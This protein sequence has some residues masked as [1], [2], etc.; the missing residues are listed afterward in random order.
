MQFAEKKK[1]QDVLYHHDPGYPKSHTG[2]SKDSHWTFV[3]RKR[4][5]RDQEEGSAPREQA[6]KCQT[7]SSPYRGGLISQVSPAGRSKS[8]GAALVLI[9]WHNLEASKEKARDKS[10][11]HKSLGRGKAGGDDNNNKNAWG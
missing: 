4:K 1:K 7:I 5:D 8:V 10:L 2:Q 11:I 3:G 9:Q 6:G